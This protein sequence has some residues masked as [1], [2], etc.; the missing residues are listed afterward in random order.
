[1]TKLFIFLKQRNG[2][3]FKGVVNGII[4]LTLFG[5]ADGSDVDTKQTIAKSSETGSVLF[6]IK[7]RGIRPKDP[8]LKDIVITQQ[9]LDCQ[10]AGVESVEFKV[11]DESDLTIAGG[12]PWPCLR[13]SGRIE[14]I[15]AG[16]SRKFVILGQDTN[17]NNIYQGQNLDG[18][19]IKAGEENHVGIIDAF[20][21]VPELLLPTHQARVALD[22]VSISWQTVQNADAYHVLI[23]ERSDLNNPVVNIITAGNSYQ[24]L[25]LAIDTQYYWTIHA[26]DGFENESHQHQVRSFTTVSTDIEDTS[27]PTIPTGLSAVAASASQMDLSWNESGDDF[28]VNGYLLYREGTLLT[29]SV[30]TSYR[31]VGLTSNTRYCYTIAAFDAA[32]NISAQSGQACGTTLTSRVWYQDADEDGFGNQ[33][34][35]IEASDQL[36]GYVSDNSDCNDNNGTIHP[37]AEEICGDQI[38]QNCDGRDEDCP[39]DPDDVDNDGDGFTENQNDCNDGNASIH[40]E[41]DDICGDQIDQNCDGRDEVCPPDP[42]DVDND[43]DGF[44]ENQNDCNDG[45]ASI[46]PEADDIC[47][48]QIDQNCDGRDEVCPPDPNDVDND[49]DGFTE[50]E[51]DCNDTDAS[52]NP[53]ADEICQDQIDQNCDGQTDENCDLAL[54]Y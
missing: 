7:W 23:S 51:G 11:Y 30:S 32:G 22:S 12:G 18:I 1:M 44:T 42:D 17:G 35:S 2:V 8:I 14:L 24:P 53:N 4:G 26:L 33:N 36:L 16:P 41:A 38:D 29:L 20:V 43:G 3:F 31:D 34:V 25:D 47:G 52:I 54:G 39:P 19:A 40:P 48:D 13:H 46:H 15:P 50:N 37:G 28:A 49:G 10:N 27:P 5:C 45:N 21:F 6:K 9:H